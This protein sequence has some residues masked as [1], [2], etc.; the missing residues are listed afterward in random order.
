MLLLP[1]LAQGCHQAWS[2]VSYWF[3]SY[4]RGLR[5]VDTLTAIICVESMVATP[6]VPAATR[7]VGALT[8]CDAIVV[9]FSAIPLVQCKGRRHLG[10]SMVSVATLFFTLPVVA[11][12]C[13]YPLREHWVRAV[14]F[15][16]V[17]LAG[18]MQT[19]A[20]ALHLY[21]Q[22]EEASLAP[23]ERR[24]EAALPPFVVKDVRGATL[25]ALHTPS[26]EDAEDCAICLDATP[27][28]TRRCSH[29]VCEVCFGEFVRRTLVLPMRCPLCREALVDT[30]PASPSS[31]SLPESGSSGARGAAPPF[32]PRGI[33]PRLA[34]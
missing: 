18:K 23:P 28:R 22:W 12:R 11:A 6:L 8:P 7:G 16:M 25:R 31:S 24:S 4:E 27:T 13:V 17:A 21:R 14:A 19:V 34:P 33:P 15:F 32:S 26:P 29:P 5:F 1:C 20:L 9:V 10:I 30:T 2:A 3:S